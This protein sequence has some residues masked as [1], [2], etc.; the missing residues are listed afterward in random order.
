MQAVHSMKSVAAM[1]R[2]AQAKEKAGGATV[3]DEVS[4]V[5][6]VD[7]T[8]GLCVFFNTNISVVPKCYVVAA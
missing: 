1:L 7:I 6:G 2:A 8:R 3:A 5:G 4:V